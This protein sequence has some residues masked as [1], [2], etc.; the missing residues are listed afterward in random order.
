MH[1]CET[2]MFKCSIPLAVFAIGGVALSLSACSPKPAADPR[3]QAPLVQT[4]TATPVSASE[5]SFTGI[6]SARV[7]SDIGFPV[8]G[9]VVEP[10]LHLRHSVH[11]GPPLI[12]THPT[13]FQP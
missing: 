9:K 13:H 4:V 1:E 3:T 7:Q 5:R 8:S 6:V 12:P 10:L 2:S 11:P